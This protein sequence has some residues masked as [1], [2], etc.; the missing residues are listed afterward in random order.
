[1]SR[2]GASGR[3]HEGHL[4]SPNLVISVPQF[5]DSSLR[6]RSRSILSKKESSWNPKGAQ[7]TS[8]SRPSPWQ[9]LRFRSASS[10]R[11]THSKIP[12]SRSAPNRRI[13]N[14]QLS[15]SSKTLRGKS[16]AL[17][18]RRPRKRYMR[19]R[20]HPRQEQMPSFRTSSQ[21]R[22]RHSC[23]KWAP[24]PGAKF[25][26]W[27][28]VPPPAMWAGKSDPRSGAPSLKKRAKPE[29]PPLPIPQTVGWW[30][31]PVRHC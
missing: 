17:N 21:P 5:A 13:S 22:C 31:R 14:P 9:P 18:P 6:N 8:A 15:T 29:A 4:Y 3:T 2:R 10:R 12:R 20:P 23:K 1:L 24:G 11:P 16:Q 30:L 7:P 27:R 28:S 26:S 25:Q 19:P